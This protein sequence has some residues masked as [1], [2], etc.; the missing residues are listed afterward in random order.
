MTSVPG[1]QVANA[2]LSYQQRPLFKDLSFTFAPATWTCLLGRSGCG[3]SSLLRLI[4][5]LEAPDRPTL[6]V[7]DHRGNPLP[8]QGIAWM[9]QQDALLPWLNVMDNITIGARLR[10][11]LDDTHRDQ[12]HALLERLQLADRAKSRPNQLSGG[13]R[14]RVALARTLMQPAPIVLMDEPFSA[15]DAITRSELHALSIELLAERTVLMVTHDPR[16]ALRL[17]DDIYILASGQ[18]EHLSTR[19]G[20]RPAE[21]S[22]E[23]RDALERHIMS[24]LGGIAP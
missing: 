19:K 2:T 21:L 10:N 12:A 23:E 3:K 8:P 24:Q 17:S 11:T 4:A 6:M 22:L 7:T 20:Q 14:Q 15:V 18:L 13:Q 5:G 9:A 1:L 16:E